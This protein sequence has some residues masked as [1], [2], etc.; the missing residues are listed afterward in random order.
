MGTSREPVRAEGPIRTQDLLNLAC[1]RVELAITIRA[2][3]KRVIHNLFKLWR[4]SK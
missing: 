4:M 1:Q 2:S 3:S